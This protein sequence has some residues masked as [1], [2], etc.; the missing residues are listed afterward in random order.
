MLMPNPPGSDSGGLLGGG[1][2]VAPKFGRLTKSIPFVKGIL[3]D[4]IDKGVGGTITQD[5]VD[6]AKQVKP[7]VDQANG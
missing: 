2:G 1:G 4:I 5:M 7:V 6:R 3:G